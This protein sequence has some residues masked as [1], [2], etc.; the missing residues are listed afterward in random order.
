MLYTYMNNYYSQK[1]DMKLG[2]NIINWH[3][4]SSKEYTANI[5]VVVW[6]FVISQII[7]YL[8]FHCISASCSN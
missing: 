3:M 4:A 7:V 5:G 8:R 6:A 1:N 2:I